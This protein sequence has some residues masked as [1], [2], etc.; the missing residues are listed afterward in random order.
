MSSVHSFGV[1]PL[2][3][4]MGAVLLLGTFGIASAGIF[5]DEEARRAILDLRQVDA[6]LRQQVDVVK[7]END[8]LS[9]RTSNEILELRRILIDMQSQLE[10]SRADVGVLRG[11]QEQIGRDLAV[12]QQSGQAVDGRLR[13]LEPMTVALEGREFLADPAEKKD[14]EASLG[15]FRSGDFGKA[16]VSFQEFLTQYPQSGYRV[17]GL[18]WLGNA[19]YATKDYR[20]AMASFRL[21]VSLGADHVRVPEAMLAIA[22][23]QLELKELKAARKTLEELVVKHPGSEASSAAKDRLARFK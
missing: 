17:S 14:F 18:F 9:R 20:E 16:Q 7:R 12:V 21:L 11:Q 15:V 4:R 6:E 2:L 13:K 3:R 10:A 19:Q 1:G 5:D 8:E 23:C 22:N